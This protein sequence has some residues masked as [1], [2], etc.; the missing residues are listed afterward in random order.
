MNTIKFSASVSVDKGL[1]RSNNED[2][3]YFNGKYLTEDNRDLSSTF[4][5]TASDK[6]QIYGVFDGMGGEALGE[7]ASLIASQVI[8]LYHKKLSSSHKD[9]KDTLLSVV[10]EANSK[11]CKKM[12]E[13]GEKRIGATFSALVLDNDKAKI[14]NVGD[15]RVYLLRDKKLKQISAD[16]TAAQR[17]VNLGIITPEEARIHK[18]RHKLTQHLGIFKDEMIIEPHISQDIEVKKGDKFLLCSDGLTDMLEDDEIQMILSENESC[19]E[20][21]K[22]LVEA[23]LKNGGKDNVT[24]I[25]VNADTKSLLKPVSKRKFIAPC[26]VVGVC[27]VAIAVFGASNLFKSKHSEKSNNK[28]TEETVASNIYFSNSVSE[29]PVGEEN[30]FMIAVEPAN[31]NGE[32]VFE[33]SDYEILTIDKETGFY[34]ALKPGDVTVKAMLSDLS[35]E[36]TIKV[37]LPV[38]D[39]TNVPLTLKLNEGVE[40]KIQYGL[41][42]EESN[43]TVVFSSDNSEIATVSSDGVVKGIKEGQSKITVSAGTYSETIDVTVVKEKTETEKENKE[44][45]KNEQNSANSVENKQKNSAD[46]E[47]KSTEP[48]A[49]EESEKESS[50]STESSEKADENNNSV[51][52]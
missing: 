17:L 10:E 37:Y 41:N 27:L 42:P 51:I 40:K 33:T 34:K 31:A 4:S 18:D 45:T 5:E 26:L 2:N 48:K 1:I 39:I 43:V 19:E 8:E 50:A 49:G 24:V 23:A 21:T 36:I 11:I 35:C 20:I 29:I 3:F 22:A 16:D 28:E 30:T 44:E 13:S 14:F 46:C 32:I 12:I 47:T 9:I 7:E 25:V 52:G 6:L 38:S 15:S